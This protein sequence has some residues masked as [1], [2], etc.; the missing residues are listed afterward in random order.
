MHV[1]H[2]GKE[3]LKMG[4]KNKSYSKDLHRQAYEKLT[5]MQAFGQ[6]KKEAVADGTEKDK[7]FSYNTYQTY[8]KHTKYFIKWIQEKYPDC[9]TL[10]AARRHVNEWLQSRVDQV[11]EKGQHLSAWTIQTEAAALNKLYQIDKA[12]P[13]RFQ[14]PKRLRSEIKRSRVATARDRHFS[15][16]NNDELIKFCRGTGC[17]RAVLE[18]LEG[19]DLW[20]R[21]E[22]DEKI[23]S[24]EAKG[25]LSPKEIKHLATLKD[26]IEIFPQQDYFLHHRC[27]KNGRYRFAPIIGPEKDKIIDRMRNTGQREKVWQYVNSNADIHGY[28]AD[29]ATALYKLYA[30][31]VK[32][33]PYDRINKGSGKRYKSDVYICRGDEAGRKLD[34][35]AMRICSKALGH[36]RVS[37][38]AT[39]YLRGI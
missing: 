26:A 22:M 21:K 30:R 31:P 20:S 33:I 6:S 9:T 18:K 25:N 4:R 38:V 5:G 8:W 10:K 17:R 3:G 11:D 16:T 39:N 29:Y 23:S 27:D 1:N 12:D 34:R 36:N 7:I 37:V 32:D 14:P 19:R 28:R 15:V 35:R 24:L 2:D 13:D